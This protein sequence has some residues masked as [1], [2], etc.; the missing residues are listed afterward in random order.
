M[1]TTTSASLTWSSILNTEKRSI[2]LLSD[3]PNEVLLG[4][5]LH[6]EMKSWAKETTVM[7]VHFGFWLIYLITIVRHFGQTIFTEYGEQIE[8]NI[9]FWSYAC[10]LAPDWR[11][12]VGYIKYHTRLHWKRRLRR[13]QTKGK[14]IGPLLSEMTGNRGRRLCITQKG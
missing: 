7:I 13:W 14:R 4:Q 3:W 12:A 6:A 10:I 11:I 8:W 1:K 9:A 5:K 2:K